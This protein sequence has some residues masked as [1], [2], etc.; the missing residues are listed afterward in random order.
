MM[1]YR[2]KCSYKS[3]NATPFYLVC[4]AVVIGVITGFKMAA[5]VGRA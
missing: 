3:I 1:T 5:V 2:S 4:Q